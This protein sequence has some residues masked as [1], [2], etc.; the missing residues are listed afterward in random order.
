[1]NRVVETSLIALKQHGLFD[2]P[3]TIVFLLPPTA[4]I[5]QLEIC[6]K[7]LNKIVL[8]CPCLRRS[9]GSNCSCKDVTVSSL[10]PTCLTTY[11]FAFNVIPFLKS[12]KPFIRC[13]EFLVSKLLICLFG[14]FLQCW[15]GNWHVLGP[16][17]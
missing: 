5:L 16:C 4:L 14:F 15:S 13:C 9:L 8:F 10:T 11:N 6:L 17:P 2:F 7:A 3:A 1:M 12:V